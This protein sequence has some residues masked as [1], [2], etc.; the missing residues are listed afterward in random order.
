MFGWKSRG[1]AVEPV[2]RRVY[3]LEAVAALAM[4]AGFALVWWQG[5]DPETAFNLFDRGS[6][7]LRHRDPRFVFQPLLVLWLMWPSLVISGVR[8]LT[9]IVV[10]PVS[11][12]WLAQ[13]MWGISVLPLVH[14][15]LNY[16]ESIPEFS[17]LQD[18]SIGTGFWITG[19]AVILLG[20]A[21]LI[22]SLIHEPEDW[23]APPPVTLP[24]DEA[25]VLWDGKYL[26][27]P[28]CGMLNDPQARTCASCRSLL[29][30]FEPERKRQD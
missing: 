1:G 8:G 20:G 15:Y 7:E 28:V 2:F 23:G 26:A 5:H 29:F 19:G 25:Q 24:A 12:R 4:L 30:N 13:T 18:G 27:C 10:Q 9:G 11:F 14:F 17:P 16:R 21:L 6:R 22:E 3:A